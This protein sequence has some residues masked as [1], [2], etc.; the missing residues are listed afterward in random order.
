MPRIIQKIN[1]ISKIRQKNRIKTKKY[2][3]N[4]DDAQVKIQYIGKMHKEMQERCRF[5]E[6]KCNC[7][8]KRLCYNCNWLKN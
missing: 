7:I 6:E 2:C 3:Q 4:F 5:V 8:L 1:E